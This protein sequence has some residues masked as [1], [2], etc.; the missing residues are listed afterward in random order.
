MMKDHL[1][2][3]EIIMFYKINA[4]FQSPFKIYLFD[5]TNNVQMM[6]L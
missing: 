3:K 6:D 5:K 1:D 4:E 2:Q